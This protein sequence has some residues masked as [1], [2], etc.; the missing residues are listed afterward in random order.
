MHKP[1]ETGQIYGSS[2][3]IR[4]YEVVGIVKGY[5]DGVA[6]IEQRNRFFLGDTVEFLPFRGPAFPQKV[7]WLKDAEMNDIDAVP[8]PQMLFYMPCDVPVEPFSFVRI[9]KNV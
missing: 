8:H 9:K 3:Y 7:T 5:K 2:S 1:D 4:D 6:L